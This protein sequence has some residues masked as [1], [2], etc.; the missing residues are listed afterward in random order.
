M[1]SAQKKVDLSKV[2]SQEMLEE[3]RARKVIR[4]VKNETSI[5]EMLSP[6]NKNVSIKDHILSGSMRSISDF[7]IGEGVVIFAERRD[8]ARPDIIDFETRLTVVD[9]RKI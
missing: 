1:G 6:K 9:W 4:E 5:M 3:L 7:L 2:D 8:S